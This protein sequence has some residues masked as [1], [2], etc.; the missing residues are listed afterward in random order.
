[1]QVRVKGRHHGNV[2]GPNEVN[3]VTTA[4]GDPLVGTPTGGDNQ[5][6]HPP[7]RILASNIHGSKN[8]TTLWCPCISYTITTQLAGPVR[9]C[10]SC[11]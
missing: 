1:M 7:A 4:R 9:I 3:P 5:A 2:C 11:L 6:T 8:P 10:I